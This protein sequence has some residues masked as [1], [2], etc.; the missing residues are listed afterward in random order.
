MT[1]TVTD[2]AGATGVTA[3]QVSV[4]ALPPAGQA[5][6]ADAFER[7]TTGGLGAAD[8]GGPWTVT[9]SSANYSVGDGVGRLRAAAAGATVNAYLANVSSSDADVTATIS[10]QE[11]ATGS[12]VYVSVIGRRIGSDDY[13]AR[14]K[15]LATGVVQLQLLRGATHLQSVTLPAI[16]YS[17]GDRLKVRTQVFG[18]SPTTIRAKVWRLGTAEPTG[19]QAST[20]DATPTMQGPG[21]IGVALYLGGTATVVP[22]IASFDDLVAGPV[23]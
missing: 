9:G 2:N 20:T 22:L 15:V 14:I 3:R 13:R 18:T 16:T 23:G 6:A 7:T 19:W 17:T 4:A 8:T 1:L 10:L 5:F 12:G 11:Q 21:H